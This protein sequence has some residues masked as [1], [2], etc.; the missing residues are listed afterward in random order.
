METNVRRLQSGKAIRLAPLGKEDKRGE[1]GQTSCAD[2]RAWL[3]NQVLLLPTRQGMPSAS[4]SSLAAT[5]LA[6]RTC[7]LHMDLKPWNIYFWNYG[8]NGQWL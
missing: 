6:R 3:H 7:G 4:Y 1:G 5:L 2:W 8:N